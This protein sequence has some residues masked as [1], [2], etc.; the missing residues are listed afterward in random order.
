MNGIF[1]LKLA[2][3]NIR[4]N[5][6]TYVPYILTCTGSVMMFDIL[7]TL[8][9]NE[10]IAQMNGGS[11]MRTILNL[12]CFITTLFTGGFLFYTNSF[13]MNRRKME[14]GL[15]NI[16]GMG[17]RHI[18]KI[19]FFETLIIAAISLT[20]GIAGGFILSKA[21]YL[22]LLGLLEAPVQWGFYFS[23]TAAAL[24]ILLYGLVFLVILAVNLARVH[25][26]S[27]VDLLHGSRMGEREP[28]THGIT[29]IAGILALGSGYYMAITTKNPALAISVFFLAS[30]LVMIG[31]YL[32]FTAGSIAL[33]K[34]LKRRKEFYYKT[35]HFIS[36]SGLLYRMKQNAAG[37]AGIC[38]LSTSVLVMLS[39]TVALYVGMDDVLRN[40]FPRNIMLE[41]DKAADSDEEV[42]TSA[43]KEVL[44]ANHISEKNTLAYRDLPL[45]VMEVKEGAFDV[46]QLYTAE[47]LERISPM[48]VMTQDD[49]NRITGNSAKLTEGQ[50]MV[51]TREKTY[52]KNDLTLLGRTYE[53]V[54]AGD[55][56]LWEGADTFGSV[57]YYL[58]VPDMEEMQILE[59]LQQTQAEEFASHIQYHYGFDLDQDKDTQIRIFEEIMTKASVIPEG[60][61]GECAALQ[62][63]SYYSLNAGLLFLG[64]FLG[65]LFVMAT[66]LIIYYKQV[67]EGYDDKGRYE[68][69]QK[70]GLS[71]T[72]I[73]QSI[74]SQILLM[75]FLPLAAAAMHITA[76]FPLITK[77]LSA[78]NLTNVRLFAATTAGTLAVF[79]VIY[80]AVYILTSRVYLKIVN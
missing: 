78:M 23:G 77:L 19:L 37:L 63:A 33:L 50:C 72:E 28:K 32:L 20:A 71:G 46:R 54:P 44:S 61:R 15:Y 53:T 76:A 75:F 6:R 26:S 18:G 52:Q 39:S 1:Y 38:I 9:S 45:L 7:L 5:A 64:L 56:G 47:D 22:L 60:F 12:G 36:V 51:I 59:T 13:L 17:K 8:A 42:I 43:V 30:I 67:T 40:R 27:P 74:R 10:Q 70:V 4:K 3:Q 41:A 35:S 58:I 34:F 55:Y 80:A 29:A 62:R 73:K 11:D 69:M 48:Y 66:V 65:A 2:V 68:I 14:I 21:V 57:V 49:Y 31:T 79:A 24:S 25:I 16:L